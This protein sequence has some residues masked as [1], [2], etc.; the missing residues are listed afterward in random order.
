MST[1]R[2]IEEKAK[3]GYPALYLRTHEEERALDEI[4]ITA[5][6]LG[7]TLFIWTLGKGLTKYEENPDPKK[8]AAPLDNTDAPDGATAQMLKMGALTIN[9]KGE[10]ITADLIF[11]LK[12]FHH[13]IGADNP[14]ILAHLREMM[15]IFK[16][17]G[18]TVI[19]LSPVVKLPI[20]VEKEFTL[21][22]LNLPGIPE[23]YEVLEATLGGIPTKNHPDPVVRKKLVESAL[24]LTSSEAGNAFALSLI[25]PAM[26][27]T[28]KLWDHEVVMREKCQAV[29]KGGMLEFLPTDN[30]GMKDVGGMGNLKIWVSKRQKAFTD[31]AKKFGLPTPKGMLLVGPPGGGKS[32]GA[33]ALSQELALPLLR[34]DMGKIFAG[35]VG[36]SEENA[37][38]VIDTAEAVAPCVLWLDEIEKGFA[39]SSGGSM[40]SGVGARVLGT[41]LTWMQEK[42]SAVFVYAT[43][44]DVSALPPE[45]LRKG[46]FDE[47]FSVMLPNTTERKEI[48]DIHIRKRG[49]SKL[50]SAAEVE[51]LAH[52]T[53]GYSGAEI[54]ACINESMFTAFADGKDLDVSYVKQAVKDTVPLS[55][56]M[57]EKIERMEDWCKS[58][59]RPANLAEVKVE[60]QNTT[61][62]KAGRNIDHSFLSSINPGGHKKE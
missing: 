51:D 49:R 22:D 12:D 9:K 24:G 35:L 62:Q 53:E 17:S 45:L 37:R 34:C 16:T 41:F 54:E 30:S 38:K 50:I 11:V 3:A 46:R 8:P 15:P 33:R 27:K 59:T 40:D 2:R 7:R 52:I 21:I 19:V 6:N 61:V 1:S 26:A 43:A 57:S 48:F 14:L 58:R 32:L 25:E 60:V 10:P 20:E 5:K 31:E 28:G 47:I 56:S 13:F 18:T 36:A 23:L 42:K 4:K 39:G 44:N 55:K 29:K